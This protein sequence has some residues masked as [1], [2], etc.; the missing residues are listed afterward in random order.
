M[1][2]GLRKKVLDFYESVS[3][4]DDKSRVYDKHRK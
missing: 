3:V 1:H 2:M 4:F